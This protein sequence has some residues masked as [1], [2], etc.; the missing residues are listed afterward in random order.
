[1][2]PQHPN[3]YV[4][5]KNSMGERQDLVLPC[6]LMDTTNVTY[7]WFRGT[8]IQ[9]SSEMVNQA[10]GTLRV[11]NI[12]EGEYASTAGVNYHCIASRNINTGY[13]ASVRSR[14][15]TVFYACKCCISKCSN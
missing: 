15:V 3:V 8:D 12:T 13:T 2:I 5:E 10:T 7:K 4:Y 11:A 9:V 1:M 6:P 14:T